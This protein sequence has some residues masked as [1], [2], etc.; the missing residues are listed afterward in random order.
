MGFERKHSTNCTRNVFHEKE[1]PEADTVKQ[2]SI[3]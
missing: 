3:C 1:T 2:P